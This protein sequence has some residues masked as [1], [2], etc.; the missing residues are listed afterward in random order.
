[1]PSAPATVPSAH[2][3]RV[4]NSDTRAADATEAVPLAVS[5]SRVG[6]HSIAGPGS[7]AREPAPDAGISACAAESA[8]AGCSARTVKSPVA[9]MISAVTSPT[10]ETTTSESTS[11]MEATASKPTTV[12]TA[13]VLCKDRSR[14]ENE[15]Q[16]RNCGEKRTLQGGH[17][18]D[19]PLST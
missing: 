7:S 15:N 4:G 2:E 6:C 5:D 11:A 14:Q 10:V 12:A 13:T 1:M 19:R 18:H 3:R 16:G 9:A 8:A 17:P